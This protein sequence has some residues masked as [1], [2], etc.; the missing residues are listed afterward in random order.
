M[1]NAEE[2]SYY[3]WKLIIKIQSK[4]FI[5]LFS[6][7]HIPNEQASNDDNSKKPCTGRPERDQIQTGTHPHLGDINPHKNKIPFTI[8]VYGQKSTFL[9]S[10][11][12]IKLIN[13]C[14][15]DFKTVHGSWS[16]AV[17]MAYAGL[18][19]STTTCCS[20]VPPFHNHEPLKEASIPKIIPAWWR[21]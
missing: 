11:I 10:H 13:W 14:R 20:A 12:F 21:K 17:V 2:S 19:G 9:F 18:W 15:L 7:V 3:S 8:V 5:D 16:S 1:L 6:N 4:S